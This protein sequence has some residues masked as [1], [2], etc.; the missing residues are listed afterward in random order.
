MEVDQAASTSSESATTAQ[1]QPEGK[2]K[3][4]QVRQQRVNMPRIR[5]PRPV[6]NDITNSTTSGDT[7]ATFTAAMVE[8]LRQVSSQGGNERSAKITPHAKVLFAG[9]K[10]PLVALAAKTIHHALKNSGVREKILSSYLM[11]QQAYRA[12]ELLRLPSE[13][14]FDEFTDK[15]LER[16]DN[17]KTRGDYKLLLHSRKQKPTKDLECFSDELL[18]LADHAYPDASLA[19]CTELARDQFLEGVNVVDEIR[20]KLFMQQ[21]S[22]LND[23]LKMTRQLESARRASS[24]AKAQT[25][26]K[27]QPRPQLCNNVS[28]STSD[29]SELKELI[30]AMSKR[31]DGLEKQLSNSKTGSSRRERHGK[32]FSCNQQ[33][34]FAR[35]CPQRSGNE[36]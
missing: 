4:L 33:G 18:E 25:P 34:H 7:M 13:P 36:K 35:H 17:T 1:S 15:L 22:T 27:P 19:L 29:M 21:P 14:T 9:P 20:E 6:A 3:V 24:I 32:C 5:L 28:A 12:F 31:M 11:D 8:A 2:V 26:M 30:S 10:L 16:F 23:A